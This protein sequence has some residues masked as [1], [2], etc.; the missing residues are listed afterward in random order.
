MAKRDKTPI[1]P[2]DIFQNC[3][4]RETESWRVNNFGQLVNVDYDY[5]D[6][7]YV[8]AGPALDEVD[9]VEYYKIDEKGIAQLKLTLIITYNANA[10][11]SK[12]ERSYGN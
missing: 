7:Q 12:V 5:F 8:T 2:V 3:Y 11:I 9:R 1:A 4:A 10:Q 6:V